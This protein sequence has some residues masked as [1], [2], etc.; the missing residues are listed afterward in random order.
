[1]TRYPWNS[2]KARVKDGPGTTPEEMAEVLQALDVGE[3]RLREPLAPHT[4]LK[5]GGPAD[6]WVKVSSLAA[7]QR[8]LKETRRRKVAVTV[9]GNGSNLLVRDGGV[10]GVV[11]SLKGLEG[12]Q[13][14]DESRG[15]V[16]V[17]SGVPMARFIREGLERGFE[18]V[19]F[20][21]GI[22]G[23]L[24]GALRM[25]AGTRYGEIAAV[26]QAIKVVSAGGR[27]QEIPKEHLTFGYRTLALDPGGVIVSGV[28]ELGLAPDGEALRQKYR[29]VLD[30][31]SSTQPLQLPSCGSVFRNPPREAAGRLIEDCG[32]K[33]VRIRGAQVSEKHANWIVNVGEATASDVLLLMKLVHERVRDMK[34]I[35]LIPE[36]HVIGREE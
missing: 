4:T 16:E 27:L 35:E 29:E 15:L 33:G 26:V 22:P 12:Y 30:Y 20:L 14:L 17:E 9:L 24:G 7:L 34:G 18:A 32:L 13:V 1:M 10:G 8:L 28:L 11:V 3:I 25:N 36:V 6:L 31:R 23:T 5:V 2:H 21:T 19:W